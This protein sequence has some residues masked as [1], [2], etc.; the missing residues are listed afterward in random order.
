MGK[1]IEKKFLVTSYE[2]KKLGKGILYRQGYIST[3]SA[4]LVRVRIE[5]NRAVIT[6]K[7]AI[8]SMSRREFEYGIP[9]EDAQNM[10]ENLCLHPIIQKY[11]YKIDYEGFTWEV[12]EFLEENQGL[13]M[14]EIEL[15]YET[16]DFRKP[17]WIGKEVTGDRKYYNANLVRY[18]FSHWS[19]KEKT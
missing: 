2:F 9:F 4:R 7:G 19:D 15:E 11:R 5:G 10:L 18:P 3:E 17:S 14:A 16:Q 12:D 1:E 13:L 8:S 6:I